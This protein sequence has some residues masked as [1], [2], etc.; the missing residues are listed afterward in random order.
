MQTKFEVK[1]TD[2][3]TIEKADR[4][5]KERLIRKIVNPTNGLTVN[6]QITSQDLNLPE[7][8]TALPLQ[9]PLELNAMVEDIASNVMGKIRQQSITNPPE[10]IVVDPDISRSSDSKTIDYIEDD[11]IGDMLPE[12]RDDQT[13]QN[14][15]H[16]LAR[17]SPIRINSTPSPLSQDNE[18]L[19]EINQTNQRE[20]IIINDCN[21]IDSTM[22]LTAD[23]VEITNSTGQQK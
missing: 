8:S 12:T 16:S 20:T 13:T 3:D 21:N 17:I 6:D 5:D 23:G 4:E 11:W 7:L 10:A 22:S 9:L 2:F 14:V 19:P 1:Q 15:L 18:L